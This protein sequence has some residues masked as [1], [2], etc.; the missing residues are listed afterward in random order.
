MYVSYL[1]A[2]LNSELI[3]AHAVDTYAEFAES[4]KELL[5]QMEA[6]VIAK[7]Y[8]E[9]VDMYVFDEF[10]T[11]RAKGIVPPPSPLSP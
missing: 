5:M 3:E 8:Y 4:N 1:H 10:Q 7:E 6:P 9:A 11:N 2:C